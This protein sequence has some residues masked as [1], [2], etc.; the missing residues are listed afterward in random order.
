MAG[1]T[2]QSP[3]HDLKLDLPF[4]V[5]KQLTNLHLLKR[6]REP[7]SLVTP[8]IRQVGK[9]LVT[10]HLPVFIALTVEVESKILPE[11][12]RI[13]FGFSA[14]ANSIS[15]VFIGRK[16]LLGRSGN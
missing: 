10:S 3:T 9:L 2:R 5:F 6:D 16:S 4:R 7:E 15:M 11:S 13:H 14:A 8:N 1:L 12:K